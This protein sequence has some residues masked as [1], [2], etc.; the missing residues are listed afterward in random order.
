MGGIYSIV[1]RSCDLIQMNPVDKDYSAT[2]MLL[3]LPRGQ[4]VPCV[5]GA[6]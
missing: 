2:F 1:R 4:A 3:S 6:T 5:G